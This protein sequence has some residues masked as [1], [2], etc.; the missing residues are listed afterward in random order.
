MNKRIDFTQ[1]GGFPLTQ[2]ILAFMQEGY[3]GLSDAIAAVVGNNTIIS[4]VELLNDS[5][6]NGWIVYNNELI[7]FVGG[8]GNSVYFKVFT[9][10]TP[11][12]FE[13][14]ANKTVKFDKYAAV[15]ADGTKLD[16]LIRVSSIGNN[17]HGYSTGRDSQYGMY[18]DLKYQRLPTG[19]LVGGLVQYGTISVPN[20]GRFVLPKGII[21]I[22]KPDDSGKRAYCI[23]KILTAPI[24]TS[25]GICLVEFLEG[26]LIFD[27]SAFNQTTFE[28]VRIE[29]AFTVIL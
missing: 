20:S 11:L 2:E 7:P 15:A 21:D 25:W 5:F 14:G 17:R 27:V 26:E 18:Y 29:V 4:G 8:S 23:A 22:E 12:V 9:T 6:T 19:L 13:D 10:E 1:Q 16:S 28:N 24:G 3:S